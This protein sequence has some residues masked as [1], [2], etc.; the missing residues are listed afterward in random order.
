M[1]VRIESIPRIVAHFGASSRL[2]EPNTHSHNSVQ[3]LEVQSEYVAF[4]FGFDD[5]VCRHCGHDSLDQQ[6]LTFVR[7]NNASLKL[8]S[9]LCFCRD[10]ALGSRIPSLNRNATSANSPTG[11]PL[12][13]S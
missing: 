13:S 1:D 10:A 12:R 9:S 7:Q 3:S 8:L 2:K 4:Q 11:N 5:G 6:A